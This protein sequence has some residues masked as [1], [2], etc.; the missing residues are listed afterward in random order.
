MQIFLSILG[1]IVSFFGTSQGL[2]LVFSNISF[3]IPF[4]KKMVKYEVY[5]ST[6]HKQLVIV[7][8]VSSLITFILACLIMI[9]VVIFGSMTTL[10]ISGASFVVGMVWSLIFNRNMI[11]NTYY[12]V[13]RFIS[14]HSI[15]MDMDKFNDIPL[16]FRY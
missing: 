12:N 4:S 9:P 10:W 3:T 16:N 7:D 5:S 6:V 8:C 14:K 2:W 13:N 11:G 1:A 15:C